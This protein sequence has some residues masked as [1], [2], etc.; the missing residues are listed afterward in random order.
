MVRDE[1][2]GVSERIH[3]SRKTRQRYAN[4]C[5]RRKIVK[6]TT[7]PLINRVD[8]EFQAAKTVEHKENLAR[9]RELSQ[10]LQKRRLLDRISDSKP[11]LADRIDPISNLTLMYPR[12]PVKEL[13]MFKKTKIMRCQDEISTMIDATAKRLGRVYNKVRAEHSSLLVCVPA[14]PDLEQRYTR[15]LKLVGRFNTL[16]IDFTVEYQRNLTGSRTWSIKRDLKA[17][18]RMDFHLIHKRWDE[19]STKLASFEPES[20]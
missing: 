3:L 12:I 20:F 15:I 11:S 7:T 16:N 8:P 10:L 2:T 18:G 14:R 17:I 4:V 9:M 19:I 13:P 1:L 6:P 5:K